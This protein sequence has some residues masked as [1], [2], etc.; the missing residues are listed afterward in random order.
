MAS[1]QT[2][3]RG[4][5]GTVS[6]F[7]GVV[8]AYLIISMF[9]TPHTKDSQGWAN[10]FQLRIIPA[11]LSRT[12]CDGKERAPSPPPSRPALGLAPI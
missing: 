10:M 7:Q 2:P 9:T 8:Q 5:R 3:E 11:R 6:G 1:M 12:F 4:T